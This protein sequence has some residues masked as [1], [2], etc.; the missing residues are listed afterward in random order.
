MPDHSSEYT[1]S[2]TSPTRWQTCLACQ[3][4]SRDF[5]P[6]KNVGVPMTPRDF[7]KE[8]ERLCCASALCGRDRRDRQHDLR[9]SR[10]TTVTEEENHD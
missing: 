6:M 4:S 1:S 8:Q 2:G 10:V 3:S 9:R 7:S 5:P